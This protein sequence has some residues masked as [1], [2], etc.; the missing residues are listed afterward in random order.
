MYIIKGILKMSAAAERQDGENRLA[1]VPYRAP[2]SV[3][4]S[5]RYQVMSSGRN[6]HAIDPRLVNAA[7]QYVA[8]SHDA[9][10]DLIA[11]G[12]TVVVHAYDERDGMMDSRV[13]TLDTTTGAIAEHIFSPLYGRGGASTEDLQHFVRG[14]GDSASRSFSKRVMGVAGN[15]TQRFIVPSLLLSG[16]AMTAPL[17]Y[18]AGKMV[19]AVTR[20]LERASVEV[21]NAFSDDIARLYLR[22]PRG[23]DGSLILDSVIA[24][25]HVAAVRRGREMVQPLLDLCRESPTSPQ[26][27]AVSY[28][29]K[30]LLGFDVTEYGAEVLGAAEERVPLQEMS[31]AVNL[32]MD[33]HD[34]ARAQELMQ[35]QHPESVVLFSEIS[36]LFSQH[37][38]LMI[39]EEV[40][41]ETMVVREEFTEGIDRTLEVRAKVLRGEEIV[42]KYTVFLP[43][44][45]FASEEA[46]AGMAN[47]TVRVL[48]A[49]DELLIPG[50]R[51]LSRLIRPQPV[52][53]G[54]R[55]SAE[56]IRRDTIHDICAELRG[57]SLVGKLCE[58]DHI[59][60]LSIY[61][62][63]LVGDPQAFLHVGEDNLVAPCNIGTKEFL[64][65]YIRQ[66]YTGIK[67]ICMKG[68]ER[69]LQPWDDIDEWKVH[70]EECISALE[71]VK[72]LI[73]RYDGRREIPVEVQGVMAAYR[74]SF[75]DAAESLE[76]LKANVIEYGLSGGYEERIDALLN[77][78]AP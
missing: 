6:F 45:L 70:C 44:R 25:L 9:I 2:S 55:R 37:V 59:K 76:Q 36:L 57:I 53:V 21:Y 75:D 1:I 11:S 56:K 38:P 60:M 34:R 58:D 10:M 4:T 28:I 62:E 22:L 63:V 24:G 3:A 17:S 32:V 43:G 49:P 54:E 50:M 12:H 39:Y 23:E 73:E 30:A 68:I 27:M 64:A 69:A 8:S 35:A 42:L 7:P 65:G 20:G 13:V 74:E 31:W 5:P 41:N 16:G 71:S 72:I 52:V 47:M 48:N 78:T 40:M 14:W 33:V 19:K 61:K 18:V 77:I 51:F 29:S 46:C 66:H 26:R 15:V 67:R